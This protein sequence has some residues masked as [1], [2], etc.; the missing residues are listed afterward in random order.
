MQYR[1][2]EYWLYLPTPHTKHCATA[3]APT[4][5]PYRPAWH[6][7][8]E[9]P[10]FHLPAAQPHCDDDVEPLGEERPLGH[11]PVHCRVALEVL[12]VCTAVPY[13]PLGQE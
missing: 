2:P 4:A 1:R 8:H 5:L 7:M 11:L 12:A 13:R 6:E 9:L 3:V 10:L